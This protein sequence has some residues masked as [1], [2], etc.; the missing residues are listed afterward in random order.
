MQD[1]EQLIRD[2]IAAW[3][4]ATTAC[5]LNQLLALMSDD[6]VFLLPGLPPMRGKDKF[7]TGFKAAIQRYRIQ[8]SS[9]IQEIQ[10]M[11]DWAY[12]WNHLSVTVTPLE[13]GLP[14]RR[15][16]YTLT[17]LQKKP[18]GAWIIARDANMLTPEPST[19]A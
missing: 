13:A 7:A 4:R 1:D 18:D 8:S 9:D 17:I 14:Q 2:L 5:D 15:T 6:V 16:G 11:G 19:V 10:I 3:Q 12:C